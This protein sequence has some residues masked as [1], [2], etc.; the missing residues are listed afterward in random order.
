LRLVA[1]RSSRARGRGFLRFETPRLEAREARGLRFSAPVQYSTPSAKPEARA[2]QVAPRTLRQCQFY[3][4]LSV[5]RSQAKSY[6]Q[7]FSRYS[8]Y[9]S[10]SDGYI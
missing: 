3:M 1:S 7:N 9:I 4:L 2:L 5:G 6:F 10:I 8:Q